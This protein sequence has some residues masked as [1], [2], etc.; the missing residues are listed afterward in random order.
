M[1]IDTHVTKFISA[2]MEIKKSL[3]G[4][5]FTLMFLQHIYMESDDRDK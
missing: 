1:W 3:S 5:I 4:V 2:R